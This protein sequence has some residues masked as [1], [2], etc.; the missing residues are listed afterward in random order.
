M[1]NRGKKF[2]ILI[3]MM[4]LLFSL[5]GCSKKKQTTVKTTDIP[6][7]TETPEKEIPKVLQGTK[8]NSNGSLIAIDT[9]IKKEGLTI[10][11]AFFYDKERIFVVLK[12][13]NNKAYI[14]IYNIYSGT[15]EMENELEYEMFVDGIKV[16]E[17]GAILLYTSWASSFIYLDENLQP[18]FSGM[19]IDG[20]YA[21][22][23]VSDSGTSFYYMDTNFSNLYQFDIVT[24]Q[25]TLVMRITD[26]YESISLLEVMED[27]ACII[28]NYTKAQGKSGALYIDLKEKKIDDLSNFNSEVVVAGPYIYL[29]NFD[30]FSKGYLEYTKPNTLRVLHRFN[31]SHKNEGSCFALQGRQGKILSAANYADVEQEEKLAKIYVYNLNTMQKEREVTVER[32]DIYSYLNYKKEKEDTEFSS[33]SGGSAMS[34]SPNSEVALLTY[35]FEEQ[36]FLLW[37]LDDA[38]EVVEDDGLPT[39]DTKPV[40]EQENNELATKL[41]NTYGVK[42]YI[43]EE[44]VRFFPDFAV[45]ALYDEDTTKEALLEVEKILSRFP[46]KFFK[47]LNY[48]EIEGVE[49]YLCG[50]LVQGSDY[51]IESPGGFAL[52]FKNKQMI[53]LDATMPSSIETTLCHE[54]MHAID[55]RL[56]YKVFQKNQ[57]SYDIFDD[58]NKLN[59]KGY[60]YKYGYVDADGVEYNA[61]NNSKYTSADEKS[62]ENV[63]N[64]YFIDY[65]ANT[66]PTE[67]RARIFE[68]LMSAENELPYEFKSKNLQKKAKY[69]CKMIRKA[70]DCIDDEGGE[71][72]YWE[73]FLK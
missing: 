46:K 66:Y 36:H 49:I 4:I 8:L 32:E 28:A 64:I 48:G 56:D 35:F 7:V 27:G 30:S 67:D 59:P 25:K 24:R 53:V 65:Y 68:A 6:I 23:A 12:D 26:P 58:W 34:L 17:N 40:T 41:G 22:M 20:G 2:R 54:I 60:D 29:N 42:L 63:N 50:R 47:E 1:Q 14:G 33:F 10:E 5:V 37:R 71:E 38:S 70:M 52:Q 62:F 57:L 51:G 43:R 39:I 55:S 31:F 72:L 18:I 44:V 21:T 9:L 16:C 15:Y 73:K 69:L 11:G 19:D 3:V 45:N 61:M 13:V